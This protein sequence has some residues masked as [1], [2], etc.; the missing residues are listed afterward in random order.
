MSS[1]RINKF[2]RLPKWA[3]DELL[4]LQDKIMLLL[5]AIKNHKCKNGKT[6]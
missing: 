2:Q 3:Q 6:K 5:L 4:I 1:K